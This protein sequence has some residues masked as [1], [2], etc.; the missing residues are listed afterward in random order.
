MPGRKQIE[1]RMTASY[2]RSGKYAIFALAFLVM[3]IAGVL[4]WEVFRYRNKDLW[5]GGNMVVL[6]VLGIGIFGGNI[7]TMRLVKRA[8]ENVEVVEAEIVELSAEDG[9]QP[10]LLDAGLP[11]Q[12]ESPALAKVEPPAGTV[13]SPK[14]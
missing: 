8:G 10:G 13:D 3:A 7:W 14:E 4:G 9:T 2:D 5:V 11:A 12:P 6:A 1:E